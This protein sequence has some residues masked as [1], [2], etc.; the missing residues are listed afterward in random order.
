LIAGLAWA[1]AV[2]W[3]TIASQS[4]DGLVLLLGLCLVPGAVLFAYAYRWPTRR[5]L[6]IRAVSCVAGLIAF[7]WAATRAGDC[8]HRCG[9]AMTNG[10]FVDVAIFVVALLGTALLNPPSG[11]KRHARGTHLRG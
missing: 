8:T 2:G 6:T 7:G 3:L 9:A 5:V 1:A 4:R 10:A 11:P